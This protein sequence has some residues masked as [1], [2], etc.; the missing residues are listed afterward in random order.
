MPKKIKNNKNLV[1]RKRKLV[2]PKASLIYSS[3]FVAMLYKKCT[4][5]EEMEN[6]LNIDLETLFNAIA[7]GIYWNNKFIQVKL[8]AD[9]NGQFV[10]YG[11]DGSI[12]R[13][14]DYKKIWFLKKD[15]SE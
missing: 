5:Y 4:R 15:R 8:G 3:D 9:I 12:F 13:L 6:G 10:L 14:S 1:P 2:A 7:K 11:N